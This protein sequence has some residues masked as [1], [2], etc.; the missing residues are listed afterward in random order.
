MTPSLHDP[1]FCRQLV[2]NAPDGE[3]ISRLA[4]V[5]LNLF[6]NLAHEYR[7]GILESD[8]GAPYIKTVYGM[9]YQWTGG[10]AK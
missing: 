6:A 1:L 3:Q 7:D 9:G 4:G 8:G 5:V 10:E 2:A